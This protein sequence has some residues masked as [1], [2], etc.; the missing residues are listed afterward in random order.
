MNRQS[1]FTLL[2]LLLSVTIITML[3]GVGLP[4]YESFVRRNDLDQTTTSVVALL[5]RAQTYATGVNGDSAWGVSFSASSATLFKGTSFGGRDTNFDETVPMPASLTQS[6]LSE[7]QFAKFTATPSTTGS[8]TLT[9][10][11]N[12]ARTI[13]LNAKG[14]VTY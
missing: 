3:A 2:E 14:M 7:V 1:G 10:T 8:V 9:S 6:G 4:V 5:R 11:I 13:T 12:D